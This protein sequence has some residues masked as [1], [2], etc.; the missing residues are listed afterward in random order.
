MAKV[1]RDEAHAFLRQVNKSIVVSSYPQE[2]IN[3]PQPRTLSGYE[4]RQYLFELER[5]LLTLCAAL[6]DHLE[7][8]PVKGSDV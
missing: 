8:K 3:I 5:R 4:V 6:A 2:D 7:G 1:T